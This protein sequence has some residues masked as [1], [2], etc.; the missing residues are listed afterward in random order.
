MR[1]LVEELGLSSSLLKLIGGSRDTYVYT[2][3]RGCLAEAIYANNP[4]RL[5]K[6][7]YGHGSNHRVEDNKSVR[8]IERTGWF[9]SVESLDELHFILKTSG[10]K[11]RAESS[12][13]NLLELIDNAD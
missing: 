4:E 12:P 13:E 5:Q 3:R 1:V 6:D 10:A 7:W 8:D 9:L 2:D 11:V